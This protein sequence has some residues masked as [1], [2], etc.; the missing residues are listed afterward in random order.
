MPNSGPVNALIS[1]LAIS[2]RLPIRE[3]L[4]ARIVPAAPKA[5]VATRDTTTS[6]RCSAFDRSCPVW[7]PSHSRL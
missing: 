5:T 2:S 1:L 6:C 3:T 4:V 7:R